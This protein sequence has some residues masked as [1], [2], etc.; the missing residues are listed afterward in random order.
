MYAKAV[1]GLVLA[2]SFS[3]AA[4][5]NTKKGTDRRRAVCELKYGTPF[6]ATGQNDWAAFRVEASTSYA[7][8]GH[9][10][11]AFVLAPVAKDGRKLQGTAKDGSTLTLD[12]N[13]AEDFESMLSFTLE[14]RHGAHSHRELCTF[15]K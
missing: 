11:T 12:L 15:T 5:D 13:V 9:A 14:T 1:L 7:Y 6:K 2:A 3:H 10:P 4:L 8:H